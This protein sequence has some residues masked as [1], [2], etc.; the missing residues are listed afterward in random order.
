MKRYNIEELKKE[1]KR[2]GYKWIDFSL[3]G[4]RSTADQ[5][6]KFDDLIGLIENNTIT[7]FTGTTNPGVHWLHNVLSTKGCALLKPNQ[8]IDTYQIS[9][10]QGKYEALCQRKNVTVYRDNDKDNFSEET[11]VTETGLFGINIHRANPNVMS[12][13]N[14]KYSA[15]CQVLNNPK[16]FNQLLQ[17]CKDSKLKSFTYTLLKEFA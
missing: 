5:P 13:I 2:L 16:E 14:G 17:K 3:V 7:W 15:G 8:Y 1:Y 10:H 11:A 4:I 6:D 9:L 12:I